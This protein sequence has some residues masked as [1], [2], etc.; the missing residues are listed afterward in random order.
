MEKGISR[1]VNVLTILNVLILIFVLFIS[2]N[3]P[4]PLTTTTNITAKPN[5]GKNA[6]QLALD[7]GFVG[8]QSD[9]MDSLKGKDSVSIKTTEK[10]L[11]EKPVN[12]L[13]AKPC[14]V[15]LADTGYYLN[16]PN[17]SVLI[18]RPVDGTNGEDGDTI[19]FRTN[20]STCKVE[21]KYGNKRVWVELVRDP[22]CEP[23]NG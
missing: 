13:D 9:Y 19:L 7:S 3:N 6:Y 11:Q 12:G 17:S 22:D 16:C 23:Q 8:T 18:P 14:E 1:R 21:Y 4:T 15:S 2:L 5:D 20:G 10:T